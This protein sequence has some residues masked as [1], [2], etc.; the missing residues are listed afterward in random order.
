M[1][2]LKLRLQVSPE[3]QDMV[4]GELQEYGFYGFEQFE[5]EMAAWI[6]LAE[7]SQ[8][9]RNDLPKRLHILPFS[10][11]IIDEEVHSEKN[12]NK[13]WEK[14]IQPQC[15]GQFYIHPTWV[16]ASPPESLIPIAIDPKM[17]FGT[18][19]HETTRM[20]LRMIPDY[21]HKG[22]EILDMGTGT[23]ILA[24]SALKL[25]ASSAVGID[26]DPWSY[27]NANDNARINGLEG[28]MDIRIGSAEM[29]PVNRQFDVILANINTNILLDLAPELT[30]PLVHGGCLL[31][32]GLLTEDENT[33]LEH[34]EY[35]KLELSNRQTENEWLALVLRKM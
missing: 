2:Y 24:I 13:E 32:S 20:L 9:N 11:L 3:Y 34:P 19:Y 5:G 27:D 8:Q 1:K 16:D 33:I 14:T 28:R 23:G 26:I 31:L 35:S 17:A 7:F 4:I 15:I 29:I 22:S 30:K 10:V 12:W 18:G 25:G 6:P 21:V